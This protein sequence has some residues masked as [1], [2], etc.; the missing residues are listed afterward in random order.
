M[1]ER[2]MLDPCVSNPWSKETVDCER[3]E[4]V[5]SSRR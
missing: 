4:Y 5:L 3:H 2:D 1:S